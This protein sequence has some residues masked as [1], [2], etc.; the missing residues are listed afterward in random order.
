MN[1][2]EF[3]IAPEEPQLCDSVHLNTL[4]FDQLGSLYSDTVTCILDWLI[5]VKAVTV[6]NR[7]SDPWYHESC[8]NENRAAGR[9]QRQYNRST[10][11]EDR[12]TNRSLWLGQLRHYRCH[13]NTKCN[14]FWR[15]KINSNQSAPQKLWQTIDKVLGRR[16]APADDSIH[17]DQFHE[18][19]DKKS[20]TSQRLLMALRNPRSPPHQRGLFRT[21]LFRFR[22]LLYNFVNRPSSIVLFTALY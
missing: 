7:P 17:T 20:P 18:L 16:R 22:I 2:G 21:H 3:R 11:V 13:L 4:E 14:S 10:T 9:L 8:R 15:N 6:R 5:P 12:A 19:F 1:V